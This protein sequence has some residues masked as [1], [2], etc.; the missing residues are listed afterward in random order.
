[1]VY[2][3]FSVYCNEIINLLVCWLFVVGF[4]NCEILDIGI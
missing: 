2:I 3:I 4:S 1:M